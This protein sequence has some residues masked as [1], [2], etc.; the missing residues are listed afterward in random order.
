M[1]ITKEQLAT[2][3]NS[4]FNA[5]E[6]DRLATVLNGLTGSSAALSVASVTTSGNATIGGNANVAGNVAVNTSRFV[7]DGSNGNTT[8]SGTLNVQGATTASGNITT[9]G[10]VQGLI[11]TATDHFSGNVTGGID[12]TGHTAT[13]PEITGNLNVTG[14]L[15]LGSLNNIINFGAGH[16]MAIRLDAADAQ[17]QLL[18]G[19]GAGTSEIHIGNATEKLGFFGHSASLLQNV[20]NSVNDATT[21]ANLVTALKAYGIITTTV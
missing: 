15:N 14:N 6:L 4:D 2:F 5:D 12:A 9:S 19:T 10:N 7:V 13:I 8:I 1:A 16:F 21:I 11:V 3:V 18:T 17:L 20:D